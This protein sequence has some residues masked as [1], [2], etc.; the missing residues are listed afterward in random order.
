MY[1]ESTCTHSK[2]KLPPQLIPVRVVTKRRISGRHFIMPQLHK[3]IY[4]HSQP[5]NF[6]CPFYSAIRACSVLALLIMLVLYVNST[7]K[8]TRCVCRIKQEDINTIANTSAYR[9]LEVAVAGW[10]D[11]SSSQHNK[12]LLRTVTSQLLCRLRHFWYLPWVVPLTTKKGVVYW[13]AHMQR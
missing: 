2:T 7:G 3:C 12:G 6:P 9:Q 1:S 11:S 13:H 8:H 4:L 5:P 10:Q